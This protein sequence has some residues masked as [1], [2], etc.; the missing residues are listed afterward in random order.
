[1]RSKV[2]KPEHFIESV[3]AGHGESKG[4]IV[5]RFGKTLRGRLVAAPNSLHRVGTPVSHV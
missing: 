1:M 5:P 3:A 4:K 2:Q